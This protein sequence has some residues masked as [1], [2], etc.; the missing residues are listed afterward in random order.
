MG[1]V[2]RSVGL[3]QDAA[4]SSTT[5]SWGALVTLPPLTA[6][7]PH[8]RAASTEPLVHLAL[9]KLVLQAT[10]SH[11]TESSGDSVAQARSQRVLRFDLFFCSPQ[12]KETTK[13]STPSEIAMR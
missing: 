8:G 6:A 2:G 11:A 9:L 7:Q 3:T 1:F 10:M 5:T 4:V 13:T 12:M